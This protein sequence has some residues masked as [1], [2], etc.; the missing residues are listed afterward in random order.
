MTNT[1]KLAEMIKQSPYSQKE[2]AYR[3]GISLCTFSRKLHNHC[4]FKAEEISKLCSCLQIRDKDEI[5]F[6]VR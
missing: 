1:Q 4:Q 2:L 6:C 5:F 3:L